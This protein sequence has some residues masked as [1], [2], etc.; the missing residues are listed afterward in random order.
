VTR[1]GLFL[2]S[3]TKWRRRFDDQRAAGDE[4]VLQPRQRVHPQSRHVALAREMTFRERGILQ[5]RRDNEQ[6][7][8]RDSV[9]RQ[10]KLIQQCERNV[11]DMNEH[12][13]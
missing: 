5:L 2:T 12:A 1:R 7:F 10:E 9:N 8:E 13:R 6:R 4:V 3:A 11:L